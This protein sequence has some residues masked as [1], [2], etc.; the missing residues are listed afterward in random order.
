MTARRAFPRRNEKYN[1]NEGASLHAP[2]ALVDP[3][4]E[5]VT[6]AKFRETI[7]VF[8]QALTTQ[9]NREVIAPTNPNVNS[10][11]LRLRDFSRMNPPKF[12]GFKVEEDPNGFIDEVYKVLAIM[13][14][15]S[16]EK[17]ELATYQLKY[18]S[19]VLYD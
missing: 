2:Q 9:A 11:A 4:I 5:N 18:V 16:V 15:T 10:S 17:V 1:I 14:V 7:N 8:A 19:Q 13:G 6:H 12:Y 3:L